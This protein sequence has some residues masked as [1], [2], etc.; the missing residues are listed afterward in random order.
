LQYIEEVWIG[1]HEIVKKGNMPLVACKLKHRL[2]LITKYAQRI[3]G[4]EER[5]Q[6]LHHSE[7]PARTAEVAS[8]VVTVGALPTTKTMPESLASIRNY[9]TYADMYSLIDTSNYMEGMSKWQ[10]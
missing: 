2:L 7:E 4:Q 5:Q 10:R 1:T 6:A 9:L 8:N 3:M